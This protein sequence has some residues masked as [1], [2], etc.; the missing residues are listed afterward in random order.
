MEEKEKKDSWFDIFHKSLTDTIKNSSPFFKAVDAVD[1]VN[2]NISEDVKNNI[3]KKDVDIPVPTTTSLKTFV[4]DT[5]SKA[6]VKAGDVVEQGQ[7]VVAG[8]GAD[9][10]QESLQLVNLIAD[11]ANIYEV[12]PELQ[13]KQQK[14]L[15][16]YLKGLVGE[17]SLETVKRGGKD[18]IKIKEPDSMVGELSRDM[19]KI[20]GSIALAQKV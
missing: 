2:R 11:K 19:L 1:T 16:S 8:A 14:F 5:T 13:D 10:A 15:E 18:I 12:D 17:E 7:R 3:R 6:I 20:F 9:V 4:E